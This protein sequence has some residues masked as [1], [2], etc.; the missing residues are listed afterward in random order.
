MQKAQPHKLS[1]IYTKT[2]SYITDLP[3]DIISDIISTLYI[4]YTLSL[5][6]HSH[7]HVVEML[8]MV[9]GCLKGRTAQSRKDVIGSGYGDTEACV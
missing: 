3:I 6:L 5:C 7:Y 2:T 8:S 9:C 1:S 4:L